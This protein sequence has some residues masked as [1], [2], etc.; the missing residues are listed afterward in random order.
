VSTVGLLL[1][2]IAGSATAATKIWDGGG[3]DNSWQTG[4]NWDANT[5]PSPGDA[6]VFTNTTRLNST[7]NFP[8]GTGFNGISFLAPAGAFNLG[9]NSISLD[10]NFSFTNGALTDPQRFYLLQLP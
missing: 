1:G 3:T 8:A 4:A 10:G 9:G 6:L 5:A 2:L 7:N